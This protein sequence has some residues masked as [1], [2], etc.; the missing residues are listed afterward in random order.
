MSILEKRTYTIADRIVCVSQDTASYIEKK[1]NQ[2][3]SK[4]C[5]IENGLEN[6]EVDSPITERDLET[7]VFVGRL[8]ERKGIWTLLE[9]MKRIHTT[10]PNVRLQLIGKNLLGDVLEQWI[11][12]HGLAETII[13]TGYLEDAKMRR[14]L[15]QATALV[16]PS[17]LE[18][19]GLIAAEGMLM[20]TCVVVSDAY[21]LRSIIKNH[22]T[23]LVFS[24]ENVEDCARVLRLA[25]DDASL[26]ERVG[27][28]AREDA[29][30]RF[31]VEERVKDLH[32]VFCSL[33]QVSLRK[34]NAAT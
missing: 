32:E 20:G 31:S 2:S 4:I 5:V 13:L 3:P 22:E 23:G 18:G 34:G 33:L 29:Q 10:H 7:L 15:Q 9:A 26:R 17:L 8:E 1:Y 27:K 11:A 16:V 6:K 24:S 21:G 19:F 12:N 30:K 14:A 25:L 28:A